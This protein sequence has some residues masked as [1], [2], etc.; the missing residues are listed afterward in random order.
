MNTHD[1]HAQ[2]NFFKAEDT[3]DTPEPGSLRYGLQDIDFT[4]NP[5]AT[6]I[7]WTANM[8][9]GS[10]IIN[11]S[12]ITY[13][14]TPVTSGTASNVTV[15]TTAPYISY[16]GITGQ[17]VTIGGGAAGGVV[18]GSLP[19]FPASI[20]I[21]QPRE[22]RHKQ[23]LFFEAE[24]ASDPVEEQER[25]EYSWDISNA[26]S[27]MGWSVVTTGAPTLHQPIHSIHTTVY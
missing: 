7:T 21:R 19:T 25:A 22:R 15:T 26:V 1:D 9:Y 11:T 6:N 10:N 14:A 24:D 27:T 16:G 17:I 18:V 2:E 13:V 23:E 12:S 8:T 3:V 20:S 4:I 5:S